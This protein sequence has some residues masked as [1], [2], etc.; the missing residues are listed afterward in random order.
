MNKNKWSL[1]F[2]CFASYCFSQKLYFK[3]IEFGNPEFENK[4]LLLNKE[5]IKNYK[6][7]DSLKYHDNYFRFQMLDKDYSGALKTIYKIR[8]AYKQSY[9]YYSKI[10]GIQFE[11]Y[12]LVK[13]STKTADIEPV[14]ENILRERYNQLPIQ[15]RYLIPDSFKFKKDFNKNEVIKILS[16]SIKNDSISLKNAVLLCRNY[17]TYI[18]IEKTFSIAECILKKLDKEDILAKDSII[19]K[20]QKGNEIALYYVFNKSVKQPSILHFSGYSLNGDYYNYNS[21]I[22]ANRGYNIVNAS[23]RGIYASNDQII[24]FEFEINDVNEVIEWITKQP[25]SNGK[26][27]M[28]GGSYDGFSQWAATK[29]LHP[30][31]KTIVPSASVGFGIDFPMYNNCFSPYMLR[32]L[33]YVKKET[34]YKLFNDEKE[35]LSVYNSYYKNGI[36]F[37]KLDSLYGVKN[38][39]FQEWLKHPSFD[40]FWQSK[41]PYKKDFSKINIPVL[42]FTG[43]YDADQRGAMYYFNEHHKYNKN[44]EHYLVMGPF[45][46]AGVVSGVDENYKG[47]AIDPV[48]NID[49]EDI[50]YQWFDYILKGS[51]KPEFLK[52]K[53][54]FQIMGA[55]EWQS[56][57]SIDELSSGKLKLFFNKTKLQESK[58]EPGFIAQKIDF[59]NREDTLKSLDSEKILDTIIDK[60]FIKYKLIFESDVFDKPV[61]IIG[62]FTGELIASINKKDMD[63]TMEFYEK[64]STG[65]YLKLAHDYFARASYAK[66]NTKRNLLKPFVKESIPIHN[67]FST[68]RRIQKGSKLIVVLGIRKSA[69]AQINYGTGK[70]VSTETI[71]DAKEPLDIKWYTDSYIEVA[72]LK[73]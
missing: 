35:W 9:P 27:G 47:Y 41:I 68:G 53:V 21:K 26:I 48:A 20:T 72:L 37:N 14:Y 57:K 73:K 34:D 56:A 3:K 45:G 62:N 46:H 19:I 1:F 8:N 42:T 2:L 64:L 49:I 13:N 11:L 33:S 44:A 32:W 7:K 63:I 66:D 30:A 54:N 60:S 18:T 31:L 10:I 5:L 25:W 16:D 6:E 59:F 23:S 22:N 40:R 61:E 43:Y 50:S 55:N 70:D 65:Q 36:A 71:A 15:S 29:R 4:L 51:K 39:I 67:T 24:P 38:P 12:S 69:D 28:I 52:G 58:P 17:N